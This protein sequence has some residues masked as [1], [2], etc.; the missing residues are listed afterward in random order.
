MRMKKTLLASIISCVWLTNVNAQ[1]IITSADMPTPEKA[2]YEGNDTMPTVSLGNASATSQNW[3][4]A[5]LAEHTQDTIKALSYSDHPNALFGSAN[6]LINQVT[7][8]FYG[9]LINSSSSFVLLGGSGVFNIQGYQ[10]A[11][12]QTNTPSEILFNFPTTY[13]SSF[14]NNYFTDAKF[15]YGQQISGLTIDSIHQRSSV[16]KTVLVDAWGTLTTPLG[17]PYNV[18]RV[19]EV[20]KTKDTVMAY[21][22]GDWNSIPGGIDST[23]ATTYYW[24]ANSIGTAL[25]TAN[26]D[27]S[28]ATTNIQWL[29]SMPVTIPMSVN[30]IASQNYEISIF[31]NPVN[32]QLT[33]LFDNS[34][35]LVSVKEPIMIDIQNELGQSV[36]K[37]EL[38]QL[39]GVNKTSIDVTDLSKGV[40]FVHLQNNSTNSTKKF[41]KQ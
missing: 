5:A 39:I 16:E 40:Y 24:W 28:G 4:M 33:I 23:E 14:T 41:I 12:S 6:T 34:S 26:V 29:K 22:F 36:K 38:I 21:F 18:L 13:N 11:V 15:H 8:N 25:V 17:G 27:T 35:K 1:I 3:N 20:K 37:M 10:T 32:N 7:G 19:K 31:P 9:Y 2:M 30:E